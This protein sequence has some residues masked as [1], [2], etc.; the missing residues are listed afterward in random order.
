MLTIDGSYGEGGGQILRTSASLA[1]ITGQPVR[2]EKIRAG[3]VEPGLKA[4]HLTAIQAA[5][6]VCNGNL[7]GAQVGATEVT[8]TPGSPVQPGHYDFDIGT[9]G[10]TTLV[11]QTL[12]LPLLLAGGESHVS[13]VGGTHNTNAPSSD[14]LVDTFLPAAGLPKLLTTERIGFFPRGGG[15]VVA[16]PI[17]APLPPIQANVRGSRKTLTASVTVSENLPSHILDRAQTEIERRAEATGWPVKVILTVAPSLSPGMAVHLNAAYE[18]GIGGFTAL[19]RRGL[20]TERVVEDA[21]KEF[22]AFDATEATVDEHLADQ[23]ILPALFA[24]G[25]S[26]YRTA[27]VTEHLRTMAWLVPQ[28]GVGN[29]K[30]DQNTGHVRITPRK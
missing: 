25:P 1:A 17:H 27:R 13:I 28:F 24:T 9:A 3:R 11:L 4:Q 8:M 5:M 12:L 15:V 20:P 7:E 19:G 26:E 16:N 14:Y 6:R 2:I 18:H 10:S 22:E 30:I 29:V 21:F 23:L